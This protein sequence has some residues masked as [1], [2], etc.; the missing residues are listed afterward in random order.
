MRYEESIYT[1]M[2]WFERRT[3]I[4][5][6]NLAEEGY[7]RIIQPYLGTPI[8]LPI[9]AVTTEEIGISIMAEIIGTKKTENPV[10][11]WQ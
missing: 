9:G 7:D 5:L 4:V 11:T 3:A 6:Q 1:G 10:I 8:G 2:I